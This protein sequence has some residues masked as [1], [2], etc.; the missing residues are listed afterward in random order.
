M[1]QLSSLGLAVFLVVGVA[2]SSQGQTLSAREIMD[3]MVAVYA[4]CNSY[5]DE[6]EVSTVF[7]NRYGRRTVV[8]PFSTAFARPSDFRFEFKDRFREGE[9]NNY[10]IWKDATSVKTWWSIKPGV[11]SP[12]DLSFALVAAAGVSSG[13]ATTVPTLL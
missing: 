11:E 8:K 6:G 9:W 2:Y 5:V 12:K 1:R 7:L 3:R 4:S 13:S 10:I